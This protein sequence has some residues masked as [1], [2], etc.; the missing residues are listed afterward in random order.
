MGEFNDFCDPKLYTFCSIA[1][2]SVVDIL[3][4]SHI[5]RLLGD[6]L[7]GLIRDRQLLC[8][9]ICCAWG[10]GEMVGGLLFPRVFSF[11][12]SAI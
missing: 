1:I 3:R 4:M 11:Y 10:S 8:L 9:K 12:K 7:T 6:A 2:C 5:Y